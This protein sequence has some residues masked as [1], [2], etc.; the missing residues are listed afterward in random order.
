MQRERSWLSLVGYCLV[1]VFGAAL[2]LALIIAGGSVAL[3]NHQ[4]GEEAQNDAV[5][6][7]APPV[8]SSETPKPADL[9]TFSGLVTD[10]YCGARHMRRSNLAPTECAAACIRSGASFVLINGDHRYN[11]TGSEASLSKFLGTRAS[12][13]GIQQGDKIVVHSA[14]PEF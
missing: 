1:S 5:Q 6:N 7:P 4:S 13:T 12:V 14:G 10:S 3:A 8:L 9:T 2:A 11:L